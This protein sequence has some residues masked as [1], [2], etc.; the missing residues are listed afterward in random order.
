MNYFDR[1][2]RDIRYMGRINRYLDELHNSRKRNLLLW[3]PPICKIAIP[4]LCLIVT[5]ILTGTS[6]RMGVAT[7]PLAIGAVSWWLSP[8]VDAWVDRR[9]NLYRRVFEKIQSRVHAEW[10]RVYPG[11]RD[12]VNRG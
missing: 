3:I 6:C 4:C 9:W 1:I 10:D 12:G 5:V 7:I 11:W 2:D 8:T